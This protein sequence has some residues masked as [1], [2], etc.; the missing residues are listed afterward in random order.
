VQLIDTVS[1]A[2]V[3]NHG[4]APGR[5]GRLDHPARLPG[6]QP[7]CPEPSPVAHIQPS[8]PASSPFRRD[9]HR[10]CLPNY[11][12]QESGVSGIRLG[13]EQ[14]TMVGPPH[15]QPERTSVPPTIIDV[16][17]AP[18][19][20]TAAL[21][22]DVQIGL[23]ARPKQLPP[24]YFYDDRGSELFDEITRLPEYYPTRC[25]RQILRRETTAIAKFGADTLVEL[26]SG[27]SDKTRHILSAMRDAG[28]LRRYVPFDVSEGMLRDS[29]NKIGEEFPGVEVHG[30]VGDFERHL[31]TIPR[32]GRKIAA[33]LG[34]T[35]GNLDPTA[36]KTFLSDVASALDA[37]DGF[38][39][40][41]D[42]VKP[43]DRLVRAYDDSLGITAEF[44]RNV[45]H[46][47]N[48]ELRANFD[49]QAFR[50]V[51]RWNADEERIEMWLVAHGEQRVR[52]AA[53]D[54]DVI[55]APSEG[56]RTEISC[57]FRPDGIK[58]ELAEA[59]F[60]IENMWTDDDG[61]YSLTLAR[62]R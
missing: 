2:D 19:D 23:T 54:L 59:G 15:P 3:P 48:R 43:W 49:P 32:G 6:T 11:N 8:C 31:G 4:R 9:S 37:G 20:L 22:R 17:L 16:H 21:R 28:T 27:T 18:H 10:L 53:L 1:P 50:H 57:K 35:I 24:K 51:A 25:E 55:F 41:A 7:G 30:V 33:F 13:I 56:M 38:L 34:G 39:L 40:G 5:I 61:D 47:V 12:V 62:L 58:N 60:D 42:L 44:N 36:R 52:I 26:G 46:V 45:L 14:L 29:A